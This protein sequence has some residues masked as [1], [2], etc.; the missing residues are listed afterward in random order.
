MQCNHFD[1]QALMPVIRMD[2]FYYSIH[3]LWD[4]L[5]TGLWY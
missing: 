2:G 1:G 4:G 3:R 5:F